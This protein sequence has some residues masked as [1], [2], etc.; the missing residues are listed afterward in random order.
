MTKRMIQFC[1]ESKGLS[2]DCPPWGRQS[3]IFPSLCPRRQET[4][5]PRLEDLN[6]P[7]GRLSLRVRKKAWEGDLTFMT[8]ESLGQSPGPS[9]SP[10]SSCSMVWQTACSLDWES[11]T[12]S[13]CRQC[14]FM[15]KACGSPA[16]CQGPKALAVPSG[17][18]FWAVIQHGEPKSYDWPMVHSVVSFV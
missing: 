4:N 10:A 7:D 14:Q 8:E 11:C 12:A 15:K 9:F 2:F 6:F 1:R 5:T 18:V 13:L 16:V 17:A 3:Y